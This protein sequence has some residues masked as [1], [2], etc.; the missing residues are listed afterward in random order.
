MIIITRYLTREVVNTLFAITFV[1]LLAFLSQQVV[2]YL[3]YVAIGKIPTNVL[4]E[5]VSFEIPYFLAILLPLCL[6][7]GILLAY[8]R[9]YADNEMSILHLCG[10]GQQRI[11]RLTAWIGLVVSLL[12]LVLMLWVN[13]WISAKRQQVMASDEAT[14]HL[15][16]TM[17]PGRFQVS[18]DG[19]HVMYVEKLSLDRQRAQNVFLARE[20]KN[21]DE[22]ERNSWMLVFANQ[23]YQT[24]EKNLQ[25]QFFVTVDGYRYEG[26]P[27]QNNYKIIQFKKY[28]VRVPPADTHVSHQQDEAL[29]AAQLWQDYANPKRAAELQWRFSIAMVTFLLALLAVPLSTVRPREGRYLVLIPAVLIYIVYINLLLLARRW[30][31][32]GSLT[33]GIGIWWVH[34]LVL[35]LVVGAVMW[36]LKQWNNKQ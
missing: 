7:L 6:Y 1:L 13:P 31:E 28:A 19:S 22:T 33:I 11:L 14:V 2:R 16:E 24:T 27:G 5:L 35:C 26:T 18:P 12:V 20:N 4:L 36:N 25:E 30:V 8:G 17:I 15:V 3:N 29:S 10:F 21:T 9:L 34:G 23:G 32:Q